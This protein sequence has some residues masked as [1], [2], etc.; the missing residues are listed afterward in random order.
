[1][2]QHTALL[3]LPDRLRAVG[4]AVVA[5]NGWDIAQGSYKWTTPNGR[6][7]YTYPPLGFMVHHTGT[8]STDPVVRTSNG[9]WS[10]ANGWLGLERGGRLYSSGSGVPTLYLTASG[11]ARVSSGYGYRP[12]LWDYVFNDLRAPWRAQ[13]SDGSTAANRYMFNL[14]TTHP[15]DYSALNQGVWDYIVRLGV[16]LH[17]MFGWQERTI[18]HQSWTTRKIDPRWD[19]RDD[20]II[21]IQ[22]AIQAELGGSGM[23]FSAWVEGVVRGWA[24]DPAHFERYLTEL[25]NKGRFNGDVGYYKGLLSNPTSGEWPGF[26]A[27]TELAVWGGTGA[28]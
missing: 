25:K 17:D 2:T 12:V 3:E 10:K 15:G 7:S 4:L 20:C 5:M 23:T 16:V 24:E 26:Y 13:G 14:E 19:S 28:E 11:P 9:T 18:G 1:M 21:P 27:R 6:Q 22:D 8:T